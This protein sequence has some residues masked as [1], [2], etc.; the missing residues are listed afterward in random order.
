[1]PFY[2]EIGFNKGDFPHAEKYYDQCL[3]IPMYPSLTDE[4]QS[5]VIQAIKQFFS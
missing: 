3:S 2:R 1:M 4:E 5:K